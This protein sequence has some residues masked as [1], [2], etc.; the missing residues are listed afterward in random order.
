MWFVTF[1]SNQCLTRSAHTTFPDSCF[2]QVE[3]TLQDINDN[4]PVFPTDMLDLTVEEN[5]GDGSKILQLTAMDADEVGAWFRVWISVLK[6]L[7]WKYMFSPVP[8][9]RAWLWESLRSR[10]KLRLAHSQN[11]V[12][13]HGVTQTHTSRWDKYSS[14]W[15]LLTAL[16]IRS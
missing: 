6:V 8:F 7:F 5:I 12:Q 1:G 13:Y 9:V 11:C 4:P 15:R 16:S 3:I 2:F 14:T 10:F